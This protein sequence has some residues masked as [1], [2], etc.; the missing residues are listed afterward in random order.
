[1]RVF[2]S[3][4]LELIRMHEGSWLLNNEEIS[5]QLRILT[6]SQVNKMTQEW[7]KSLMFFYWKRKQ[8]YSNGKK[9]CVIL[10]IVD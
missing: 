4:G 7:M 6:E 8:A 2:L 5:I 1:M 10:V 3:R 9:R